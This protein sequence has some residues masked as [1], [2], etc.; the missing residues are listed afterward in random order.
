MSCKVWGDW[1]SCA[2]WVGELGEL[3]GRGEVRLVRRVGE[4]GG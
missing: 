2:I 4:L 1:A 3:Q